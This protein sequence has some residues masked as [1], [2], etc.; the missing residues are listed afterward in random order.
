MGIIEIILFGLNSNLKRHLE[1]SL[2]R[3]AICLLEKL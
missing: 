3:I 1:N 2:N